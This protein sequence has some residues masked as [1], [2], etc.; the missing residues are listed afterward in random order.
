[1]REAPP[2]LVCERVRAQISLELDDELSQLEQLMVEA[3]LDHCEGCRAYRA[4]LMAFTRHV[5][6]TPLE[7]LE[8]RVVL[9]HPQR[10][11]TLRAMQ[12]AGAAAVVAIGLGTVIGVRLG[13][14]PAGLQQRVR[15][16]FLDSQ[17]YEMRLIRKAGDTRVP[18][19][20]SRAV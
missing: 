7:R 15:P 5:R 11:V 19:R 8:R 1:M 14:S 9:P 2:S 20:F 6:T 16:A 10:R 18:G 3:H 17:D 13:S 12:A 4:D